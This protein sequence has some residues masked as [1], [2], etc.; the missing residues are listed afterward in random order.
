MERPV[1]DLKSRVLDRAVGA[2]AD[3]LGIDRS[4]VWKWLEGRANL[5]LAVLKK[6]EEDTRKCSGI[7]YTV[8][9]DPKVGYH[10]LLKRLDCMDRRMQLFMDW[11]EPAGIRTDDSGKCFLVN[12]YSERVSPVFSN[13]ESA[14]LYVEALGK[15]RSD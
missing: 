9:D 3:K 5:S 2:W 11:F 10:Q 7:I 6:V 1:G 15:V 12:R 14:S 8:V 13:A 4:A